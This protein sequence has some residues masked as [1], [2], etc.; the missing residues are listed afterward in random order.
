M[1]NSINNFKIIEQKKTYNEYIQLNNDS[2]VTILE[3]MKI[4]I[5]FIVNN[6]NNWKH[7]CP[8]SFA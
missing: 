2:Q 4:N 1:K 3:K 7:Y 6:L 5:N 8:K